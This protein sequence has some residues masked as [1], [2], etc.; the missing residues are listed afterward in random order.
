MIDDASNLIPPN[1]IS[2]QQKYYFR[3]NNSQYNS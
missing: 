2:R 3:K 1:L